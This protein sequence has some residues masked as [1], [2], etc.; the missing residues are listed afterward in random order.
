MKRKEEEEE[1][2]GDVFLATYQGRRR[3]PAR[4][5]RAKRNSIGA[6]GCIIFTS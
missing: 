4:G 6:R 5:I 1:E 3:R 2:E